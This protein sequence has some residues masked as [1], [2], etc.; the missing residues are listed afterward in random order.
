M[1][2]AEWSGMAGGVAG[3]VGGGVAI[4]QGISARAA[5]RDAEAASAEAAVL[6]AEANAALHRIAAA[7]ESIATVSRPSAWGVPKSLGGDVWV[8]RNTSGRPIDLATVEVSPER[9]QAL[10]EIDGELPRQFPSGDLLEFAARAR[11]GLSIRTFTLV[12]HF[13]DEPESETHSSVRTLH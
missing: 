9:A 11:N 6:A 4:W 5:R 12:W 7:Q 8:I 2:V 3:L 13:A 10:L 1:D